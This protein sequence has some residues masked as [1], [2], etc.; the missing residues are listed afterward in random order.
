MSATADT[1]PIK[2]QQVAALLGV[3]ERTV[4]R[5]ISAGLLD[6]L[7][8]PSGHYRIEPAAVE[9]CLKRARDSKLLPQRP[10]PNPAKPSPTPDGPKPTGP[11][12]TTN[13]ST[14]AKRRP[15][16]GTVLPES[17]VVDLSDDALRALANAA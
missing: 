14:R 5:Y 8:L 15:P 1:K 2:P 7:V 6:G 13:K 16:L 4:R 12:P 10:G 11:K 17:T 9:D 3:H